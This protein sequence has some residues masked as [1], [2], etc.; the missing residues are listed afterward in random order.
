MLFNIV[1]F[2]FAHLNYIESQGQRKS[3][4]QCV[5]PPSIDSTG[6]KIKRIMLDHVVSH[7]EILHLQM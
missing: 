2:D 3:H 4:G 7:F 1:Q 5:L 6:P